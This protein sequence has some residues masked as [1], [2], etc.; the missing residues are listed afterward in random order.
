MIKSKFGDSVK[1]KSWSAQVNEVLCKI[2][3]HNIC[4]VIHEMFEL[5]IKPNFKFSVG[6]L[7]LTTRV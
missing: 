4:V 1:S 3:C 5:G 6:S 7:E 2:V